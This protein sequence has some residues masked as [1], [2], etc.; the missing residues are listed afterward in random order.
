MLDY[1]EESLQEEYEKCHKAEKVL[2]EG[3]KRFIDKAYSADGKY[4]KEAIA[5]IQ[6][7]TFN[8]IDH[9]L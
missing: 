8:N 4:G 3:M 2:K 7:M 9:I 6:Q 5:R 1:I